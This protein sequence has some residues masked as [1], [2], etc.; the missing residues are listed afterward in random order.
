M[1]LRANFILAD[2]CLPRSFASSYQISVNRADQIRLGNLHL[3]RFLF[4]VRFVWSA[5]FLFASFGLLTSVC[6]FR[7]VSSL[8]ISV[9]RAWNL[10]LFGNLHL[11]RFRFASLAWTG[12]IKSYL[13]WSVTLRQ[14]S[15]CQ[16][17]VRLF[18]GNNRLHN[19]VHDSSANFIL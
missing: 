1:T 10:L 18:G 6:L 4:A 14:T 12:L 7:F 5:N 2:F 15:S 13:I 16:I 3:S 8:K 19:Q 9:N 17:S 11:I